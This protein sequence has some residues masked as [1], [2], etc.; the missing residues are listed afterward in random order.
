MRQGGEQR[1]IQSGANRGDAEQDDLLRPESRSG[2]TEEPRPCARD[3]PADRQEPHGAR[4]PM[5]GAAHSER[6]ALSGELL[7]TSGGQPHL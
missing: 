4:I 5:R 1:G 7:G 3:R 2:V 6:A